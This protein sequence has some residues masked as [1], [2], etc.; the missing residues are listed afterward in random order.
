MELE[1]WKSIPSYEGLYEVSNYGSIRSLTYKKANGPT[2][3]GRLLKYHINA[4][5]YK[6]VVLSKHGLKTPKTIHRLVALAFLGESTLQ[7]NHK[8][9]DKQNNHL[10]NLEY[11]TPKQN[12]HHAIHM[13]LTDSR[14]ENGTSSLKN[15]QALEIK[16]LLLTS[17]ISKCNIAETYKIS[18]STVRDINKGRRWRWLGD[19]TYPIRERINKPSRKAA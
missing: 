13:G 15:Y 2:R 9:G 12:I 14:G 11:V 19:Y 3:N 4:G 6:Q 10:S 1:I 18:E 5:G 7:V 16:Q 8:D 17:D